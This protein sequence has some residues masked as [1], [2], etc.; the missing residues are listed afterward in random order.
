LY[1]RGESLASQYFQR[2]EKVVSVLDHDIQINKKEI[3]TDRKEMDLFK[4]TLLSDKKIRLD[5]FYDEDVLRSVLRSV[6]SFDTYTINRILD[7]FNTEGSAVLIS[8]LDADTGEAEQYFENI[9]SKMHELENPYC[10]DIIVSILNGVDTLLYTNDAH[11]TTDPRFPRNV[12]VDESEN[13]SGVASRAIQNVAIEITAS[14]SSSG[15]ETLYLG[16]NPRTLD[17]IDID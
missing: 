16:S 12:H 1:N 15:T 10:N 6:F 17:Y 2:E 8:G 13:E 5:A 4:Y 7:I 14:A 11:H 3:I 9:I